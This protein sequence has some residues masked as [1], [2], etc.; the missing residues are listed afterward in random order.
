M[1]DF[2]RR[3]QE[4]ISLVRRFMPDARTIKMMQE[5]ARL[6]Q[7][8]WPQ[9]SATQQILQQTNFAQNM[10]SH[11]NM[12]QTAIEQAKLIQR[13]IPDISVLQK[14]IQQ[15]NQSH[16]L[17]ATVNTESILA[18]RNTNI[19]LAA[20]N[21]LSEFSAADIGS[22]LGIG[23]EFRNI[24]SNDFISLADS[25]FAVSSSFEGQGMGLQVASAIPGLSLLEVEFFNETDLLEAITLQDV[26]QESEQEEAK[27]SL[28]DEISLQTIENLESLLVELDADFVPLWNGAYQALTSTNEDR[29]RHVLISLRELFT[30]VIHKLSPDDQV[31]G[32]TSSPEYLDDSGKPTRKARLLFIYRDIY[33]DPLRTF[34][35]KDIA[36]ILAI[37]DIL[38]RVH[39]VVIPISQRQLV[40]I[41]IRIE[42]ALRLLLTTGKLGKS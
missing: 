36:A 30:Q 32:W 20:Y 37:W 38:N 40:A 21:S 28:R 39:Q 11:A 8:V 3:I 31:R 41:K 27:Q 33:Y 6:L 12:L 16:Q 24:L 23:K 13:T 18:L 4:E 15:T 25:Y 42:G 26:D 7:K 2:T 5:Q 10:L 35:E 19:L 34:V 1:D 29:N 17:L 22:A 9:I 14:I